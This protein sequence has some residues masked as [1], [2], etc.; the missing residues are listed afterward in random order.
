MAFMSYVNNKK[1]FVFYEKA[2][3]VLHIVTNR[4]Y[5]KK[6]GFCHL[7]GECKED[8]TVLRWQ[9]CFARRQECLENGSSQIPALWKK[10]EPWKVVSIIKI[11]CVQY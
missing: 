6:H 9:C 1:F 11:K 7:E 2:A 4:L 8:K 5:Y 10:R 3:G